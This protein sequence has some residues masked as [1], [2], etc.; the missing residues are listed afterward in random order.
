MSQEIINVLNYIG[1]KIGVA[2]DWTADNVVP[3]I[4]DILGRYR[5]YKI[6]GLSIWILGIVILAIGFA[7]FGKMVVG[8]YKSCYN[9]K[10]DNIL[11]SYSTYWGKPEWSAPS[12]IYTVSLVIYLLF[13]LIGIP[14]VVG[15]MLGWILIPEIQYLEMLK[16]YIQ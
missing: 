9:T 14:I 6:V 1:E 8:N 11:F 16:G 7:Y 4:L 15:E 2:I 12:V 5:I 3:Q 10:Q 13:A